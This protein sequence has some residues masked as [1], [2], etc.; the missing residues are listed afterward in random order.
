MMPRGSGAVATA[1]CLMTVIVTVE[2]AMGKLV[3]V[4]GLCV[5]VLA[6][7]PAPADEPG[8]TPA[9]VVD[10][11]APLPGGT[12]YNKCGPVEG[13]GMRR[14]DVDPRF[15]AGG[16][17]VF[18]TASDAVF[19]ENEFW[20]IDSFLTD[21][22]HGGQVKLNTAKWRNDS[23]NTTFMVRGLKNDCALIFTAEHIRIMAVVSVIEG[24]HYPLYWD[25]TATAKIQYTSSPKVDAIIDS[26]FAGNG[27][28]FLIERAVVLNVNYKTDR[29]GGTATSAMLVDGH[30]FSE[31][32]PTK[33][34]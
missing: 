6:C 10:F 9:P 1:R 28:E 20:I 33:V 12:F 18:Y 14:L 17:Y 13:L 27:L 24:A 15:T 11:A 3:K 29:G 16:K 4:A 32:P 7:G 30:L 31:E 22:Y 21:T 26:L 34:K 25:D 5:A 8:T 23:V 19:L 2:S